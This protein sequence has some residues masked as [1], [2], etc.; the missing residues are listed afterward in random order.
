MDVAIAGGHGQVALRLERLLAAGGHRARG[1][2]RNPDHAADLSAAGAEPVVLDLELAAVDDVAEAI[3]G[4]DAVVFAAGAGP[5][6]GPAR[7]QTVDLGAATLL[8]DACRAAGVERYVMV[9]SIGAHAPEEA[10]GSMGP[11]LQ[12]KAGADEA[13]RASGLAWTI[14]RPGSLTDDPG[15]GRVRVTEELGNRG[16]VPR[17][18]VAAVLLAT[19]VDR[20]AVGRTFELFAGDTPVAE[21]LAALG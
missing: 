21:A 4:A 13:L 11:Y 8:I 14:V 7:K 3:A 16:A 1:I 15:T 17:D 5:G 2:I 6:S 19:L 20:A 10:S 9:S 18:D 12:A